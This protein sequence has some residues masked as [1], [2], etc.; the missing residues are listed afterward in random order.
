MLPLLYYRE[1]G[2][3]Y[4][5]K[6]FKGIPSMLYLFKKRKTIKQFVSL[7]LYIVKGVMYYLFNLLD[8]E[9]VLIKRRNHTFTEGNNH[10]KI[11]DKITNDTV[12][13]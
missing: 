8:R 4:Y 9:D 2:S 12:L 7:F 6:Y 1:F 13:R 5:K 3:D 11:I 10:Q